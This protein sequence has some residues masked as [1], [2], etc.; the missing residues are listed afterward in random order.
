MIVWY[1]IR[2]VRWKILKPNSQEPSVVLEPEATYLFQTCLKQFLV[3]GPWWGGAGYSGVIGGPESL[4]QQSVSYK[5]VGLPVGT[6]PLM[7]VKFLSRLNQQAGN[8]WLAQQKVCFARGRDLRGEAG[9]HLPNL[10]PFKACSQNIANSLAKLFLY[11]YHQFPQ[12][13]L[14]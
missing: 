7:V 8:E 6:E 14:I 3:L 2:F 10:T 9:Y 1:T 13:A 5:V 4:P 11:F 12:F